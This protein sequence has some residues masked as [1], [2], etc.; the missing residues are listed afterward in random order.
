MKGLFLI[1]VLLLFQN[2]LKPQTLPEWYRVCTFDE[3]VIELNTNYVM[4]S[5]R[6]TGRVRFRWSFIKPEILSGERHVKY[7]S[8]VEE[9][10]YDCSN[11]R[12]R[13]HDVRLYD[14]EGRL[15]R[16]EEV[17]PPGEWREVKFGSIMEKLFTPA[18]QLIELR[19]RVPALES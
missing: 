6:K 7:Q 17:D 14:A 5:S 8:R 16:S 12:Y 10:E 19:R 13:L 4:F 15:I 2:P 9:I 3:S 11:K 18:C 1:S